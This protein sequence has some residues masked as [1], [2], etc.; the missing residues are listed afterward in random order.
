MTSSNVSYSAADAA[1]RTQDAVDSRRLDEAIDALAAFGGRTDGGV[2]RE[3]LTPVDLQARRHLIERARALGCDVS[4]DACGNLFFRRAGQQADLPPVLTGSHVDTQPVGGKLDGAYG[5]IAGLEVIQALNDAS[6]ATRRPVEVVIWTNEEGARFGP[7]AMGSSAFAKP[8]RLTGYRTS[9]DGTGVT[10]GDALDAALAQVVDVTSCPLGHPV[11]ACVELHIEQG[12]V[13]EA[14]NVPLG[15]VTGIQGVRWF[16]VKISG[17]AAHAGTTPMEVRRDAMRA[18][19]ELAN[20]LYACADAVRAQGLRMTLGRWRVD[21]NSINT[22]AGEVEFTVDARC[23][24]EAVLAGFEASLRDAATNLDAADGYAAQV[25]SLF[26]RGM[27]R[28]APEMV[29]LIERGCAR[30]AANAGEQAPIRLTSGAFHDA[31][32]VADL[33]PT[34]MIFVPSRAGIS[35]NAA[36]YTEPRQLYL[37]AQAL[38]YVVAELACR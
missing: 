9:R 5:V 37:G 20:R 4:V 13:L 31:M 38:A 24:D 35:H 32:Y 7:G 15:V 28:F 25:Q 10:F 34:A 19:M 21:P 17:A 3:T 12:P 22:I 23:V 26:T 11:H 36:E 30:A 1:A 29:E 6:I 8:E 27:T 16:S 33:C 14:A 18:A 2:A